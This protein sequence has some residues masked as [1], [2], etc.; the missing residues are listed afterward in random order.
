M[1]RYSAG[2]AIG[3]RL[4]AVAKQLRG[5]ILHQD[6]E[7]LVVNKPAGLPVQGGQNLAV[8]LDRV[9]ATHFLSPEGHKP[10][11]AAQVGMACSPLQLN[12]SMRTVCLV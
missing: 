12:G 1:L 2:T 9:L 6:A 8:S 7:L 11:S 4:A 3:A 5:C 10:R